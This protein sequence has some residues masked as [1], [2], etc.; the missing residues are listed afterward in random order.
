M[1]VLFSWF[2]RSRLVSSRAGFAGA[3]CLSWAQRVFVWP[4]DRFYNTFGTL[5]LPGSELPIPLL[6][7]FEGSFN[8]KMRGDVKL[9]C[10]F[11]VRAR[12]LRHFSFASVLR[13]PTPA[14]TS[15]Y[16]FPPK[17]GLIPPILF[18]WENSGRLFFFA[19]SPVLT[20]PSRIFPQTFVPNFLHA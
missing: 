2:L 10:L 20:S 16:P 8:L 13:E 3:P 4:A 14:A 19:V 15:F 1:E 7:L 9:S 11:S 5:A 6:L 18:F 17:F 12:P